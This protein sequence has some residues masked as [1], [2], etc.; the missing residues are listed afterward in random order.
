VGTFLFAEK[1]GSPQTPSKE[2]RIESMKIAL[3]CTSTLQRRHRPTHRHDGTLPRRRHPLPCHR[4]DLAK[5]KERPA[6]CRPV[7]LPIPALRR[8]PTRVA[9]APN[10]WPQ[11]SPIHSTTRHTNH[12]RNARHARRA[13]AVDSDTWGWGAKRAS[14]AAD[15]VTTSQYDPSA[16]STFVMLPTSS[17]L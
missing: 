3:L 1:E 11:S 13:V 12:P 17:R 4:H 6:Q 8:G 5:Q 7:L 10:R 14:R 9:A 15:A 16:C 2:K